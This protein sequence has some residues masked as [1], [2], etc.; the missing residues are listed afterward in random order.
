MIRKSVQRFSEKIMP[1]QG[2]KARRRFILISSRF[3]LPRG[4]G[5]A[6]RF[7]PS[8]DFNF[9]LSFELLAA[10][11]RLLRQQVPVLFRPVTS[12]ETKQGRDETIFPFSRRHGETALGYQGINQTTG[13]MAV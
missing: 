2:A 8:G 11:A 5:Q 10:S 4:P 9:S 13:Q 6:E 1:K 3:S 12:D 7:P